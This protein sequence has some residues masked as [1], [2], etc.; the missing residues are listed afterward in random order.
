MDLKDREKR[1]ESLIKQ[2]DLEI[3]ILSNQ[4]KLKDQLASDQKTVITNNKLN[5]KNFTYTV[6]KTVEEIEREAR[7][8][9]PQIETFPTAALDS[10]YTGEDKTVQLPRIGGRNSAM[11]LHTASSEQTPKLPRSTAREKSKGGLQ[12]PAKPAEKRYADRLQS[13]KRL[14]DAGSGGNNR[15]TNS[16]SKSRQDSP[17][18]RPEIE[19][20]PSIEKR[21]VG[22]VVTKK[23]PSVNKSMMDQHEVGLGD[24]SLDSARSAGKGSV[25]ALDR[26][27]L[28]GNRP[29]KLAVIKP[30]PS[31]MTRK[32]GQDLKS[33]GYVL[34]FVRSKSPAV[35]KTESLSGLPPRLAR[36]L[37]KK[38][39]LSL[40]HI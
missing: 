40:I 16:K 2:K 39:M 37:N 29:H 14:R 13:E 15:Y 33:N 30:K 22:G 12:S 19:R 7:L 34:S 28:I 3:N 21:K 31:L 18:L 36:I 10:K 6:L 38:Q 9:L 35:K 4:L 17:K 26:G 8:S 20:S 5:Q 11:E 24:L 23:I 32:I 1:I 25:K 27:R